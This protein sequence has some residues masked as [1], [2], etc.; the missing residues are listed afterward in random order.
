MAVGW[1]EPAQVELEVN[2]DLLGW[3]YGWRSNKNTRLTRHC[4]RVFLFHAG[5]FTRLLQSSSF[6]V[7][8]GKHFITPPPAPKRK[9]FENGDQPAD[10]LHHHSD[11]FALLSKKKLD[12]ERVQVEPRV[13][14]IR[15][16]LER[17][18]KVGEDVGGL[19]DD[20]EMGNEDLDLEVDL[21]GMDVDEDGAIRLIESLLDDG[22]MND[23]TSLATGEG[24][25]GE[26]GDEVR[27]GDLGTETEMEKEMPSRGVQMERI[28]QIRETLV[29]EALTEELCAFL[30]ECSQGSL[31][32]SLCESLEKEE[33][34]MANRFVV[35]L[36]QSLFRRFQKIITGRVELD[37]FEQGLIPRCSL[38]AIRA[39]QPS[40]VAAFHDMD[41]QDALVYDEKDTRLLQR[42][43]NLMYAYGRLPNLDKLIQETPREAPFAIVNKVWVETSGM[44]KPFFAEK[45]VE[46]GFLK[47]TSGKLMVRLHSS[48]KT[49]VTQERLQEQGPPMLSFHGYIEMMADGQGHRLYEVSPLFGYVE[50]EGRSYVYAHEL[51]AD[52]SFQ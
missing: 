1:K 37:L 38:H 43:L 29:S 6:L 39:A 30:Q 14:S 35:D 16:L 26:G 33:D 12:P 51:L 48:K 31:G 47:P 46:L 24:S 3:H 8:S 18:L 28:K 41:D 25:Q 11:G 32:Q 9:A 34:A 22:I 23:L 4:L 52:G 2:P 40:S 19:G 44:L 21:A 42:F 27:L 36:T 5:A 20:G 7:Y 17:A 45:M 10:D 15:A 49:Y 13:P 50:V